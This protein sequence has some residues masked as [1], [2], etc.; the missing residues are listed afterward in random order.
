MKTQEEV[1]T[2]LEYEPM[3]D[4]TMTKPMVKPIDWVL[5][6]DGILLSQ[7]MRSTHLTSQKPMSRGQVY[8]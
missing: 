1:T 5:R 8:L 4:E 3:L 2:R 7:T 6:S